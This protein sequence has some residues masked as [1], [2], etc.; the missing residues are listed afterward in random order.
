[1]EKDLYICNTHYH[2]LISIIKALNSKKIS[3]VM[4]ATDKLNDSILRD[5]AL[6][7]KLKKSKIFSDI[8]IIDLTNK[9]SINIDNNLF[10]KLKFIK[11]IMLN[12]FEID[13]NKFKDIY[14]FNDTSLIGKIL[15]RQ[16]IKY[17][18]LEDGTDCYKRNRRIIQQKNWIKKAIKKYSFKFY[19]LCE[20]PNIIDV[21]VNDSN[22]VCIKNKKIIEKPK[23]ELFNNLNDIDKKLINDIFLNETD[24]EKYNGYDMIIT[25][26]L[27]EDKILNNEIE[28]VKIYKEIIKDYCK[29]NKLLIKSHPRETTNYNEFFDCLI[30]N[31]LF[32][33]EI[34]T[35]NK[36]IKLNRI[37]TISSTSINIIENCKEKIFLG[38]EWLDKQKNKE[39][40]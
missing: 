33:L 5:K 28:K 14:I 30:L 25:Q 34:I 39:R 17:H 12:N 24:L 36:N 6:I 1:M 26:P 3:S 31:Q 40:N 38:W 29:S 7:N 19:E 21:E 15:N 32:P 11:D 10:L 16:N 23:K 18:L 20:S 37:I 9:Y 2:L 35:F 4:L 13:F 27:S 22:G 8:F